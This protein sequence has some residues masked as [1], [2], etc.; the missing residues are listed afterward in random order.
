MLT[1]LHDDTDCL[2][3]DERVIIANDEVAIN[4]SHDGDLLHGFVRG[5]L[6]QHAHINFL[7][8]ICLVFDKLARLVRLLNRRVHIDAQSLL[9]YAILFHLLGIGQLYS[10]VVL[11]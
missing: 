11:A 1:V 4:L 3:R 7:Y 2:L 9:L 8:H 6:R 10:A 5:L